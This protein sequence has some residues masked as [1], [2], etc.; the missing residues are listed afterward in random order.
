[1]FRKVKKCLTA[2]IAAAVTA[3]TAVG[4]TVGESTS[5]VMTVGDYKLNAGVYIYYQNTA[6]EEAKSLALKEDPNLDTSDRDALEKCVIEEKKFIDWVNEKTMANCTEH[7]AVIHKFDELG[8]TLLEDDVAMAEEYAESLY[9]ES[10][11]DNEYLDN[12]IGQDSLEEILLNTYKA[13]EIFEH[14]YGEGGTENVQ[15][16]TLKDYYTENNVRVRYVPINLNDVDGNELDEAGKKEIKDLAQ[17]YLNKVNK[18]TDELDMLEKFNEVS[19]EYGDYIAEQS[20][21]AEEEAVTTTTA[22]ESETTETTTT[23][24]VNPYEN[25]TIITAVTTEEGTAEEDVHYSPSKK[26][27]DWAYDPATKL[28]VPEIIEDEGSL[29]LAV[30]LDIEKRMTADDLWNENTIQSVRLA[31]YSDAFQEQIDSWVEALDILL[32]Q[33]AADRYEPFDYEVAPTEA[34]SNMVGY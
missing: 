5:Y 16:S 14:I 27:Y 6:L 32:N 29:Y 12:G 18:S 34:P 7:I 11:G 20:G 21:S 10:E 8:L 19:D 4:C 22:T 1:M 15:E 2:F 9:S 30:K 25:E 31:M 17:S 28:N 24:T 23:T 3:T 26:F 13:T 33:K